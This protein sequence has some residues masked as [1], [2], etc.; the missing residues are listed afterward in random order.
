MGYQNVTTLIEMESLKYPK[1]NFPFTLLI[2]GVSVTECI[3]V[4]L[5]VATRLGCPMGDQE[6]VLVQRLSSTLLY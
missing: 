2:L 5:F 6:L 3:P 4:T 1:V